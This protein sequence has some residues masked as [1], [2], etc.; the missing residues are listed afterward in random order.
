MRESVSVGGKVKQGSIVIK[1]E[2][3]S[4]APVE[5]VSAPVVEKVAEA[6]KAKPVPAAKSAPVPHHPQAGKVASKG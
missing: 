6:P 2:T 5:V 4:G 3:S 1:L